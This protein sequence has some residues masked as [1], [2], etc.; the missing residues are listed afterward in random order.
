MKKILKNFLNGTDKK[1]RFFITKVILWILMIVLF[2]KLFYLTIVKGD[3]YRDMSENTRIRDVE[4]AAPRGN[5]YDRNGEILA[6]NKT[7]FTASILKN[8]FLEHDIEERNK[9]LRDLSRLLELDGSNI[10]PDYV[11]S[12]NLIKYKD[13]K[14]YSSEELSP[15]EK[16]IEIIKDNDILKTL[17]YKEEEDK[18]YKYRVIDTVFKS[19]RN[20]GIDLPVMSKNGKIEFVNPEGSKFLKENSYYEGE[21]VY[22][23]LGRVLNKDEGIIRNILNHPVGRKLAFEQLKESNL[24]ENLELVPMGFQD[25]MALWETKS[26]L[27]KEYPEITGKSSAKDDF[28]AIVKKS[29][30]DELISNVTINSKEEEQIKV[31]AK[32]ALELLDKNNIKHNLKVVLDEQDPNHPVANVEYKDDDKHELNAKDMLISLLSEN[33]LLK[34]FITDDDIKYIAQTINTNKNILP[35]ISVKDWTYSYEKNIDDM[36]ERFKLDRKK[37]NI[38]KLYKEIIEYY[39]LEE[40][41]LYDQYNILKLYDLI[42]KHGDLR[43]V[44]LDLTYNLSEV[45]FASIEERFPLGSGIIVDSEPIRYYPE[46]SLASHT[47][48]YIGKISTEVEK[49][50]YLSDENYN[51]ASLIGKN[52]IEESQERQLKGINGSRRVKVDN[53]GNVTEVLGETK[54]TPGNDVYVSLDKNIQKVAEDALK[55]TINSLQTDNVFNSKWGDV[56]FVNSNTTGQY[57]DASSGSVVVLNAKT[58]Q[59]VALANAPDINLNMFSTGI[60]ASDWKNL[61][62]KDERDLLAPRPLL[63]MALQSAIQPGSTFKL[64]TSLAGL[65]TGLNP[66]YT[67]KCQ[68]FIE[69][70]GR[71]FQDAIWGLNRGVHG[72]E[73]TREAIRDSC[74]YYFYNLALGV[75]KGSKENGPYKLSVDDVA[76]YAK[77]LGLG[78]K[79]GI[80]INIPKETVGTLPDRNIK[81]ATYRNLYK[82][83]LEENSKK[84]LVESNIKKEE[85]EEKIQTMLK[86]ID[87]KE[88]PSETEIVRRLKSLGFDTVKVVGDSKQ[89]FPAQIKYNYIDQSN[90]LVGDSLNVVIGQG[91]NAYSPIQMARYMATIA[92]GGTKNKVSVIDEVKDPISGRVIYKNSPTGNKIEIED[93][94]AL[95]VIKEGANMAANEGHTGRV[96]GKLP[97]EMGVKSGTAEVGFTNPVTHKPYSDYGWMIGFAP[98]DNPEYVIAAV[99]TQSG[100]SM[101]I[102]P[103]VREIMGACLEASPKV[104]KW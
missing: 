91:Q 24:E 9:N 37:D 92:N 6:T 83:F 12:L 14:A 52:G 60:S 100:T 58:G 34:E 85:L 90:W 36:Y 84:Y 67:I 31:P 44:P 23:F 77:I 29:S 75:D 66:D 89:N 51:L 41:E 17:I 87:E 79:T 50:E 8:E 22:E 74:N 56:N 57:K 35:S 101:N 1:D 97:F 46:G 95:Q 96:L 76:K 69:V 40:Y 42:N 70:G 88:V 19:M 103:M 93:F 82:S 71:T 78:E 45:T 81:K 10:N 94:S 72:N 61:F 80:D 48:G 86:W 33:N 53:R 102:S 3:Y 25:E 27:A 21:P 16:M 63:N 73:G 15:M 98:Y 54:P 43:Y 99:V 4:I 26:K 47:I 13:K 49:N 38:K 30:L 68:G 18:G 32:Y 59:L 20:K 28:V 2:L 5:I 39:E 104:N 62:P 7:V 11:L 64:A 55:E 65:E